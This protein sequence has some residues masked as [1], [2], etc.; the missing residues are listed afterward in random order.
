MPYRPWA[1][2]KPW[3]ARSLGDGHRPPWYFTC[4]LLALIWSG[5]IVLSGGPLLGVVLPA[6]ATVT[7]V[8]AWRSAGQ[9]KGG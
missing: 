2:S 1:T 6:A 7:A 9:R 5:L 3:Y 8:A 4:A